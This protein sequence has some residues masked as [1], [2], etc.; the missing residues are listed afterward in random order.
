MKTIFNL[1]ALVKVKIVDKRK[2]PYVEY[3]PFNKI[4]W[5][6][7]KEGFYTDM[8]GYYTAKDLTS[9]N[10]WGEC[11]L[12]VEDNIAYYK[13]YVQ[14]CFAGGVEHNKVFDTYEEAL[15]WG[16]EQAEKAINV[17]LLIN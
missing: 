16:N 6:N 7:T 5:G 2:C 12:I 14:L 9:G 11:S 17:K 3:K 4:F 1:E 15:K 8:G 13:P 10:W